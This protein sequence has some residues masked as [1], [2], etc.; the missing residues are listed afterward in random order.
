MQSA[1]PLMLGTLA[2]TACAAP[3]AEPALRAVPGYAAVAGPSGDLR[4]TRVGVPF[5]YAD[6]AEARR[7]AD[8]ICGSGGVDSSIRDHFH[9]GAWIYPEGCA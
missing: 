8:A 9:E 5:G 4:V 2:L 7:A 6:G 1:F 3:L